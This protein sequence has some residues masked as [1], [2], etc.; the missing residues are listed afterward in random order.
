MAADQRQQAPPDPEGGRSS[1]VEPRHWS[2]PAKADE[3]PRLR[4]VLK[5]WAAAAGLAE[6]AA[7]ML[8]LASYEAMANVVEHA[9]DDSHGTLGLAVAHLPKTNQVQVT[10][11]DEGRWDPRASRPEEQRGR[12]LPLIHRL[13]DIAEITPR[14][15]GTTVQMMWSLPTS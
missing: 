2:V 11:T 6:D 8:V 5:E 12:G 9:Y 7:E 4:R 13:A 14:D 15:S 10:I 1:C 3:L